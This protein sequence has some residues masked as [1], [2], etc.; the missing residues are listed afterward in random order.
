VLRQQVAGQKDDEKKRG[1][2]AHHSQDKKGTSIS[3]KTREQEIASQTM[4]ADAK[5]SA[6]QAVEQA[7][8]DDKA[9]EEIQAEEVSTEGG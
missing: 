1:E 9:Q 4:G 5:P 8:Q 3:T 2:Q 7:K 6:E